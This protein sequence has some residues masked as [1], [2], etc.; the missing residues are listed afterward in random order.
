M[1]IPPIGARA[2]FLLGMLV[3]NTRTV[4]E[5]SALLNEALSRPELLEWLDDIPFSH[6]SPAVSLRSLADAGPDELRSILGKLEDAGLTRHVTVSGE[7][8]WTAERI[9]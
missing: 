2:Y 1:P 4:D 9:G 7:E 3:G 5:L 8:L 6:G